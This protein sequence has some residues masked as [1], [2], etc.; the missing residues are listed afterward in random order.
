[1]DLKVFLS[2]DVLHNQ[3]ISISGSKSETNRLLLLNAIFNQITIQNASNSVDSQVMLHAVLTNDETKD[4]HHAGTAMRF[5]TAYYASKENTK[6]VLKG[7]KRM[8]ERP[9]FILVEALQTLGADITYLEKTGFPPIKIKGKVL[10]GGL[11]KLSANVSSQYISALMLIGCQMKHGIQIQL[12]GKLVSKP[13]IQMTLN[14]INQLGIPNSWEQNL[15]RIAPKYQLEQAHVIEVESDWSSASYFYALIAFSPLG[16]KIKI[17]T[18][19][20]N[21]LQSDSIV[22][23]LF[24]H[25][26]VQTIFENNALVITK[27]KPHSIAYFNYDFINCP[28]IAQTLAVTCLGLNIH[29]KFSGLETLKIKET[30]RIIALK[31]EMTKLGAYVS[32][33]NDSLTFETPK[34]LSSEVKIATYNDHRMALAFATLA[35]KVPIIIQD[36][37]IVDKSYPLFWKN[38]SSLGITLEPI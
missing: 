23:S 30:D 8:H 27:S 6:V 22:V 36:A 38:L 5:L 31:N 37:D 24:E 1:M 20:Q 25:F 11:V 26:G 4:I 35:V 28:D 10:D 9:I 14:L 15:I 19:R 32:V 33:T 17:S 16:T 34:Y 13:Y 12:E 7:S 29:G 18:F 2:K 3:H 21:S